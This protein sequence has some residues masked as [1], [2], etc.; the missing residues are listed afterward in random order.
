MLARRLRAGVNSVP[1]K[2]PP[3]AFFNC[4]RTPPQSFHSPQSKS[5]NRFILVFLLVRVFTLATPVPIRLETVRHK[6]AFSFPLF[7]LGLISAVGAAANS[8]VAC[9]YI[10]GTFA[11]ARRTIITR[12]LK[13]EKGSETSVVFNSG[14]GGRSSRQVKRSRIPA[15]A[16]C[17][18]HLL[19]Q[20]RAF[21]NSSISSRVL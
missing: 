2:E 14:A 18:C 4:G 7:S 3:P 19:I 21:T 9:A 1:P 15:P 12:Y 6:F 16:C 17:R 11:R 13:N 5:L 20:G 8:R 10:F